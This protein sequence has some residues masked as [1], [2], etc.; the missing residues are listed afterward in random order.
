MT[1][2]RK[3]GVLLMYV[4]LKQQSYTVHVKETDCSNG[5]DFLKLFYTYSLLLILLPIFNFL[6]CFCQS[7]LLLLLSGR[8]E[9]EAA[10]ASIG[11]KNILFFLI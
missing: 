2:D 10:D 8:Y 5:E 3:L 9:S 6:C 7:C 1:N 11:S 4:H